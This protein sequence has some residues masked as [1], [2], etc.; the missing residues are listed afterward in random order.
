[1]D[2]RD[3]TVFITGSTDGVGRYV[4]T[5]L[6]IAGA[7]VLVHGR[8]RTRGTSLIEEIKRAG[9]RD[10]V[11]YQADLSSLAKTRK[12]GEVVLAN[13]KRLD[14]SSAMPASAA[15]T[16]DRRGRPARTA[17]SCALP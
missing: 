13:H 9:G 15:R 3:K 16:R 2:M 5:R 12:L 10:P 17:T 11:F 8:D 4:A 6:A 14:V 7:N 1:M